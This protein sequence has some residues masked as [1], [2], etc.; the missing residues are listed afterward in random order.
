MPKRTSLKPRLTKE[1]YRDVLF[2]R[3]ICDRLISQDEGERKS[4]FVALFA[5]TFQDGAPRGNRGLR[6]ETAIEVAREV[7]EME[8]RADEDE[9]SFYRQRAEAAR[10]LGF[11]SRK[12]SDSAQRDRKFDKSLFYANLRDLGFEQA[13]RLWALIE[14][15]E[16]DPDSTSDRT[17]VEPEQG[18]FGPLS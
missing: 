6:E 14:Q 17:P 1:Q 18:L 16:D 11:Y 8:L 12:A 2:N 13:D 10:H 9:L 4:A 3:G 15:L 7:F 5:S